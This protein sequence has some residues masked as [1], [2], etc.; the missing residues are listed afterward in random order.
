MHRIVFGI[1]IAQATFAVATWQEERGRYYGEL[2]N[3]PDGFEKLADW[4]RKEQGQAPAESVHLI[5]EPT[6][7]YEL[8][9]ASFA[10]EQGWRVS[11]PNPRNVRDWAKGLGLRAKTDKQD[12]LLLAR[13][14]AEVKPP[15]WA[16]PPAAVQELESLLER[17]RDLEA[18][19]H[20]ERNR[21][22]SWTGR[23]GIASRV[24]T[25]VA[26][27]IEALERALGE[28]ETAIGEQLRQHPELGEQARA[29]QA[30]PGVGPKSV[31]PLLVLLHRWHALTGGAGSAKKLGAY[32]GL[33][34]QTERSGTTVRGPERISRRGD[35]P[36]R[37][38]LY[39][40]ALG[41][42][43]GKNALRTYYQRMIGRGKAK[44]LALVAA[45]RKILIWAWVVF[46][47][48]VAFQ[49]EK[50]LPRAA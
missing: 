37:A 22:Q 36:M 5:L 49:E 7:G 44:K 23:P 19:L 30:V 46:R 31:L 4:V 47:D 32:A 18:M 24:L 10:L 3:G 50:A 28:V 41:G 8:A 13:Y 11:L 17:K 26:G 48:H 38:R 45:S 12:A 39:M 25:N 35:R 9:L 27:V 33:D 2:A 16:P 34:P 29:L 1:D 14:G 20:Q 6:G 42:V 21:Q 15:T 43:K 40:C